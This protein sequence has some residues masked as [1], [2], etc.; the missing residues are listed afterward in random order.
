MRQHYLYDQV[1]LSLT[2]EIDVS[3]RFR[4]ET[5]G[6]PL[7]LAAAGLSVMRRA[8]SLPVTI[9]F[10]ALSSFSLRVFSTDPTTKLKSL[11][12]LW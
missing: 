9:H 7:L 4:L 12:K 1:I 6:I 3:M 11:S 2:T 8:A 5:G 10:S